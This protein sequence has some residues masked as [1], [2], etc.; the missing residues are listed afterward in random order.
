VALLNEKFRC[1]WKKVGTF[2]VFTERGRVLTKS[3]G[4]VAAYFLTPDGRVLSATLGAVGPEVF[5]EEARWALEAT[6]SAAV[7]KARAERM[8]TDPRYLSYAMT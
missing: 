8:R 2:T 6:P 7:H 1:A 3:G 5:L 4:N